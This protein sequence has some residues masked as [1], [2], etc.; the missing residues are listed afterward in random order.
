MVVFDQMTV[1]A[2][3][4]ITQEWVFW[5]FDQLPLL[6]RHLWYFLADTWS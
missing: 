2:S 3:Y 1:P 5:F 4:T 6:G